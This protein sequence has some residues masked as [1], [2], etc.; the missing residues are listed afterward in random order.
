MLDYKK[1][2]SENPFSMAQKDKEE[3]YY[4]YQK[5]LTSYHYDN[6]IEYKKLTDQIFGG[7]NTKKKLSDLPFVPVYLFKD[8][9]LNSRNDLIQWV[10]DIHN[11]VNQ[12]NHKNEYSVDDVKKIYLTNYNYSIENNESV[13]T[14]LKLILGVILLILIKLGLRIIPFSVMIPD[15]KLFGVISKAGLES[16]F[17]FEI[18]FFSK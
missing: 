3:W 8:F 11:S 7:I 16:F 4:K 10:I 9:D 17:E 15:I 5:E 1:I 13:D 12:S 14:N 6:S 18:R 2:F